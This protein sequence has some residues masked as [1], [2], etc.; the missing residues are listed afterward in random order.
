ME[1][2]E[3]SLSQHLHLNVSVEV[4]TFPNNASVKGKGIEKFKDPNLSYQFIK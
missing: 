4:Y 3:S 2:Y 1:D